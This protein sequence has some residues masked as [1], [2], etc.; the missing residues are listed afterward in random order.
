MVA[1]GPRSNA[2]SLSLVQIAPVSRLDEAKRAFDSD[3]QVRIEL[4]P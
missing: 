3:L 2:P 1:G 4:D